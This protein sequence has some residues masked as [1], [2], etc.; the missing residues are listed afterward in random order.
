MN[1]SLAQIEVIEINDNEDEELICLGGKRDLIKN[2]FS[3]EVSEIAVVGSPGD[4][5]EMN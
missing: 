1:M 5:E 3:D 2:E 4:I